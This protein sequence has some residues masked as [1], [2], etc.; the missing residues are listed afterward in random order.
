MI[1]GCG[2]LLVDWKT[3]AG[4]A[5]VMANLP[6]RAIYRKKGHFGR[7]NSLSERLFFI[8]IVLKQSNIVENNIQIQKTQIQT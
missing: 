2:R 1:N 7:R 8:F 5:R 6:N 4:G 3:V